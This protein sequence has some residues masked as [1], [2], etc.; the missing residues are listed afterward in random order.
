MALVL[1]RGVALLSSCSGIPPER[2]RSL[3]YG[4]LVPGLSLVG[5]TGCAQIVGIEEWTTASG[6]GGSGIG[7]STASSGSMGS[8]GSSGPCE[9]VPLAPPDWHG[10]VFLEPMVVVS[11]SCP[12]PAVT[13]LT[14]HKGLI[15]PGTC[16]GCVCKASPGNCSVPQFNYGPG[17]MCDQPM[18]MT[19]GACQALSLTLQVASATASGQMNNACIVDKSST[20][21]PDPITWAE[22]FAA[23]QPARNSTSEMCAAGTEL[24]FPTGSGPACIYQLGVHDCPAVGDY[25]ARDILYADAKDD[26]ECDSCSCTT[27]ATS[28]NCAGPIETFPDADCAGPPLHSVPTVNGSCKTLIANEIGSARFTPTSLGTC[29]SG[30]ANIKGAATPSDPITVCCASP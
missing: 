7:A 15:D 26:R 24:C 29:G 9:C 28:V 22:T 13:A 20:P 10:P 16:S 17:G 12:S 27:S 19:P 23:C 18:S 14:G 3:A 8:T 11:G 30:G 21:V 5:S 4:L 1:R 25:T 2:L 6:A